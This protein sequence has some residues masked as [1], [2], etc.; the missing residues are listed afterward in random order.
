MVDEEGIS[1]LDSYSLSISTS[2]KSLLLS[3]ATLFITSTSDRTTAKG[4]QVITNMSTIICN[5]HAAIGKV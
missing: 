5:W 3:Y 4:E 2:T 1:Y